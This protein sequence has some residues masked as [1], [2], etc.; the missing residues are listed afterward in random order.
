MHRCGV[1]PVWPCCNDHLSVETDVNISYASCRSS[2]LIPGRHVR[3]GHIRYQ[4]VPAGQ[5]A[6]G[7]AVTAEVICDG[8]ADEYAVNYGADPNWRD[9][10][11]S[12]I[13]TAEH[14]AR[15]VTSE[16]NVGMAPLDEPRLIRE[17]LWQ[18]VAELRDVRI[19]GAPVEAV[20]W[21]SEDA[22]GHARLSTY[23]LTDWNRADFRAGR[24]DWQPPYLGTF[25]RLADRGRVNH[26]AHDIFCARVS[27]PDRNG[28][29]SFGS[30]LFTSKFEIARS[31]V[32][33]AEI[34]PYAIRTYGDNF[35]H[36]S[37]IDYFVDGG[38]HAAHYERLP[39]PVAGKA[40]EIADVIGALAASLVQDGDCLQV[41]AGT[42][43]SA[44]YD[45]LY[46]KS[47]LGIHSEVLEAQV[48]DLVSSGVVTGRRKTVDTGKVVASSLR[49][50]RAQLDA[51]H[52][53]P[54]Y[55]VWG[56]D[57]VNS[58]AVLA[59]QDNFVAVNSAIAIDLTGQ[60]TAESLSGELFSGPGGQLD[61]VC[62][63]NTSRNGM[64]ILCLP[65]TN[66]DGSVSRIV[67]I[68]PAGTAVTVPRQWT[69]FVVTEYGIAS[70]M[71]KTL[72]ERALELIAIAHPDFRQELMDYA[73]RVR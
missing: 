13:V 27:P 53:N 52:M 40:T 26:L 63:A 20:E 16:M 29:C 59:R 67:P 55:E 33:V 14:A 58:A 6:F 5:Y 31:K 39:K 1:D 3:A 22:V 8:S 70:L 38:S 68:L 41:G 10:Y 60:S 36:A 30:L 24:V 4:R 43:S 47:D 56:T 21:T 66:G 28:Y 62:G 69:D 65:S 18:R 50:P 54:L 23:W 42:A 17:A 51:V 44:I 35:V 19:V 49:I 71:G 45:H 61:L 15:L 25:R 72:R 11:A 12:Q 48:L 2:K 57:H 34:N 64:S 7:V 46:T 9:R 37:Q 73:R 32:V